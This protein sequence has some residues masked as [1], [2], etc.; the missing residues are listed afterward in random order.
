[1]EVQFYCKSQI[2]FEPRQKK[3]TLLDSLEPKN[4]NKRKIECLQGC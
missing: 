3:L 1:M 2:K 4:Q